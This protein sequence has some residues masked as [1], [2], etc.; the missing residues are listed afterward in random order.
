[1]L[2]SYMDNFV[3]DSKDIKNLTDGTKS[4]SRNWDTTY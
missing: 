2:L 4:E 1:M 3:L